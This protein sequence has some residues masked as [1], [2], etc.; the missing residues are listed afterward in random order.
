M[1]ELFGRIVYGPDARVTPNSDVTNVDVT[2]Q[3]WD[4]QLRC[5]QLHE[6]AASLDYTKAHQLVI[7]VDS[8]PPTN[9]PPAIV[10][11]PTA[12]RRLQLDNKVI[13][14]QMQHVMAHTTLVQ[15]NKVTSMELGALVDAVKG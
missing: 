15:I 1:V 5:A 12:K 11:D 14:I 4:R 7:T 8:D 10:A 3:V 13:A 2:Y 9:K 6:G